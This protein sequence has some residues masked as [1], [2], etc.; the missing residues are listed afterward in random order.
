M[1]GSALVTYATACMMPPNAK[2]ATAVAG[3]SLGIREF[4]FNAPLVD[5][6]LCNSQNCEAEA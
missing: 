5:G 3:S 4:M 2:I 1:L 6:V